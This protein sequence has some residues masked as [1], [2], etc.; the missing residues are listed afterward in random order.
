LWRNFGYDDIISDFKTLVETDRIELVGSA[1]YHPILPLISAD[2]IR[3]QIS[4][5]NE[6][7][8]SVFGN[9]FNPSGFYASEMAFSTETGKIINEMG[10]KW[11]ILDE[12]HLGK[13]VNPEV[14]YVMD[15]FDLSVIFR[16][17][18]VSN[19]FPPESIYKKSLTNLSYLITAHD[20]ELYG[21]WH[22]EDRGYYEKAFTDHNIEFLFASK[23]LG[24]LQKT[25]K[26][27]I[28][29]AS[30]ESTENELKTNIPFSLW[31]NPKNEIHTL[32]W[33]LADIVSSTIKNKRNDP[34]IKTAANHLSCGLSSC[35]WWWASERKL[36][37]FSP[38]TWNPTEIERGAT[39]LIFAIR[40][41]QEVD[42][43]T[44]E[45]AES[46]FKKLHDYIWNKHWQKELEKNHEK[47]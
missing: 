3:H 36:G 29:R 38:E 30:W 26:I 21:H 15:E 25:K 31:Q 42:Q 41:L 16:N 33:E 34:N 8:K 6:I 22:K 28:R 11:V 9:I 18:T 24:N 10:F 7:C 46:K 39:E 13:E 14:R 23:Y 37:P 20:G 32:L 5:N 45:L 4:L 35:A 44:R 1:M 17:K 43:K 12:I 19:T 40:D 47:N 27:K 2:E